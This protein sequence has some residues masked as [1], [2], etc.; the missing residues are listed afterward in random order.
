MRFVTLP[1]PVL[2]RWHFVLRHVAFWLPLALGL[3]FVLFSYIP[4]FTNPDV[5]GDTYG[6]DWRIFRSAILSGAPYDNP[7]FFSPPWVLVILAPFTLLPP[8]VDIVTLIAVSLFAWIFAARRL[9]SDWY[10]VVLLLLTPQLWWSVW[11]GNIDVLI[12]LGLIMPPQIGLFLVLSKP[13]IGFAVALFWL[14]ESIRSGGLRKALQIYAPIIIISLLACIPFGFWP[15]RLIGAINTGW[16]LSPF[17][18]LIPFGTVLIY[19]AIRD[20]K[21]GLALISGP[22][23]A[24]YFGT[25]SLPVMVYGLFPS[26]IEVVIAILGLWTIWFAPIIL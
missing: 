22:F 11:F 15:A 14:I 12:P 8:G 10:C 6:Y 5:S 17:P 26:R 20:R 16:N 2:A 3:A 7:E 23:F 4:A 18:L 25:Q 13:Q 19:R 9:G 1:A 24:P 21:Q